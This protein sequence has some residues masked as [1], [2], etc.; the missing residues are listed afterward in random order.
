[1]KIW[2]NILIYIKLGLISP[3]LEIIV[4]VIYIVSFLI[5]FAYFCENGKYYSDN[6]INK[7]IESYINYDDFKQSG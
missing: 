6:Q 5:I 2:K 1:M 7:F 3:I 4:N